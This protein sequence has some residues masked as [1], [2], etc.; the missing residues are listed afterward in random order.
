MHRM[1]TTIYNLNL[2]A[3]KH[4]YNEPLR[5]LHVTMEHIFG[6][7]NNKSVD[8]KLI[9]ENS[10]IAVSNHK[11]GRT[12]RF[13]KLCN[14]FRHNVSYSAIVDGKFTILTIWENTQ[15]L[16][17]HYKAITPNYNGTN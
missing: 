12:V 16:R 5:T 15:I 10:D 7:D 3:T 1:T 17:K 4:I 2:D 6:P 9:W 14:W 13:T 11:T 8:N